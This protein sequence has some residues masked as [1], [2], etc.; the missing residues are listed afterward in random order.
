MGKFGFFKIL[1]FLLSYYYV[2][3][4]SNIDALKWEFLRKACFKVVVR[5][6]KIPEAIVYPY[7]IILPYLII[8]NL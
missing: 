3:Y 5:S 1:N 2:T 4:Y 6:A 7:Q 8:I